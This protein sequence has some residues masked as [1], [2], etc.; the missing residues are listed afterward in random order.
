MWK[1]IAVVVVCLVGAAYSY[2]QDWPPVRATGTECVMLGASAI[3]C[4]TTAGCV[5]PADTAGTNFDYTVA[6]FA[7]DADDNGAWTFPTPENITGSTFTWRVHWI[8]NAAGCAGAAGDDVC[9]VVDALGAG[10]DGALHGASF[11]TSQG[12]EDICLANGDLNISDV[13][14]LTTHGWVSD[15][16]AVVRLL[17]DVDGGHADCPDAD[18]FEL[19]ALVLALEVCYEVR[20]IFSGE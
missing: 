8:N 7:T 10:N 20:H 15:E 2:S 1:L 16:I 13:S 6:A 3:N 18:D 5:D 14:D 4:N 9:W 12:R 17:R 19:S 11:N